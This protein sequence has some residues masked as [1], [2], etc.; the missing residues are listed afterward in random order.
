MRILQLSELYPP[1]VG[2]T[3]KH[4]QRL[5]R[6]LALRGHQ[7]SVATMAVPGSPSFE[8]DE[9]GVRVH[10]LEGALTS[11]LPGAVTDRSRPFHP[12]FAD[13][14]LVTA[15]QALLHREQPDVVHGHNW[16]TYTYLRAETDPHRPVLHTLHDFSQGCPKRTLLRPDGS[17][18]DRSSLSRCVPCGAEQYGPLK[19]AVIATGLSMSQRFDHRKVSRFL[20][21][22]SA[23]AAHAELFSAGRPVEVVPTFIG[24][25]LYEIARRTPRPE[26]LPAGDYLL[27]V[28]ALGR[29][30]GLQVLLEAYELA[31]RPL[32]LVLIGT[33]K[34]DTPST[35][36]PGVSVHEGIPHDQVMAAWRHCRIGLVPSLWPE[37]WGQVA[38]EAQT[39][40]RP[41]IATR[42]G[43]LTDVVDDGVSGLLVPPGDSVALAAAISELLDDP[44]RADAMGEAGARR[45]LS[46][47][48]GPVADR[49][50]A[51]MSELFTAAEL[52]RTSRTAPSP[53]ESA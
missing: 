35:F 2:G 4:T 14:G 48:V 40:G 41:V 18:C 33:R 53:G 43:G 22:S 44:R 47:T 7:V 31:G 8:V 24:E 13:P 3:E 11:R 29:F 34:P 51:I 45:A 36:G 5:A 32:P 20:A 49:V 12:P 17:T 28:G 42:T 27:F 6:E 38:A 39:A 10:R 37:P 9:H 25:G 15:M 50:E 21:V 16:L 1:V 46:F 30:K 52:S 19:S 23:V 26:F